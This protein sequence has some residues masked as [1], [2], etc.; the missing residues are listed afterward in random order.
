M[1]QAFSKKEKDQ[2]KNEI[3]KRVK[4]F[5][6]LIFTGLREPIEKMLLNL[7]MQDATQFPFQLIQCSHM[8]YVSLFFSGYLVSLYYLQ[9]FFCNCLYLQPILVR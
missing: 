5:S 7:L 8:F 4:L 1:D 9:S 2:G 6:K 3:K